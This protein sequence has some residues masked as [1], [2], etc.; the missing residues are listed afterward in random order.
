MWG[1]DRTPMLVDVRLAAIKEQR[2]SI[3]GLA[4]G[5]VL[6]AQL[7]VVLDFSI[8]NV[9]LPAL[10]SELGVSAD[11]AQWVVTAYA[12]AF[13]GLLVLGGRAAD[14]F[15]R[16]RVLTVGLVGFAV[17]SAAA[18]LVLAP[19]IGASDGWMSAQFAG[20]LLGS[21]LSLALF[22][23]HEQRDRQPLVPLGIFRSRVL[24]AGDAVAGLVGAWVAAEVLVLSL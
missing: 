16:R 20:C 11:A 4:L 13:G 1:H 18:L 19:S 8:V 6:A 23:R 12:L 2:P 14:F 17:A 15:G 9:A 5:I 10:S 3:G 21:A 24:V 7:V 22:V